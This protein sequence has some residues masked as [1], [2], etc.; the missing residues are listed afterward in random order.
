MLRSILSTFPCALS[1]LHLPESRIHA[2][3]ALFIVFPTET[4]KSCDKL[5][6]SIDA[7]SVSKQRL[8]Q[9]HLRFTCKIPAGWVLRTDEMNARDPDDETRDAA[10]SIDSTTTVAFSSPPSRAHPK[11]TAK[12]SNSSI[13]IA[14]ESAASYPGLKD[15]AQYFGPISE[16]SPKPRDSKW[17]MNPTNLPW[18]RK[19]WSA[20]DFQKDVGS[21]VMRQSTLV[22]LAH[23]YALSFTFIGGTE[24]EV[25]DLVQMLSSLRAKSARKLRSTTTCCHS[26]RRPEEATQCRGPAFACGSQV[27]WDKAQRYEP[28]ECVSA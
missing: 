12:T 10:R 1:D 5:R 14:A 15:A 23:G 18:A 19:P 21:R 4:Q 2:H 8:P 27:C 17:S 11:L 9:C 7:G 26:E 6:F 20:R 24:D 16:K 25:E 3:G 13:L 22:L 28:F